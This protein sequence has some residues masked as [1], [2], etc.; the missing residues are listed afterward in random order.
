MGL[1]L[2]AVLL[3]AMMGWVWFGIWLVVSVTEV[4]PP[5][6]AERSVSPAAQC[7]AIPTKS[8]VAWLGLA[9][10]SATSGEFGPK[11]VRRIAVDLGPERFDL[12]YR[13]GALE[14]QRAKLS[15]GIVLKSETVAPD[16]WLRAVG[17]LAVEAQRSASARQALERLLMS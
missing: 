9:F 2:V 7:T 1:P 5:F 10:A 11:T 17:A 16:E 13:N 15:G 12:R 14:A 6:S 8:A 3:S 4:T